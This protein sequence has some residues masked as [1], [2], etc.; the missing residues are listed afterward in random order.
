MSARKVSAGK[1]RPE[2]GEVLFL[3]VPDEPDRLPRPTDAVPPKRWFDE[4]QA[5]AACAHP[6]R[7]GGDGD[8]LVFVHGY[9]NDLKSVQSRQRYL[10]E[11]LRAWGYEGAVVA[12][13]WPSDDSTLNY[14]EDR[15]DAAAT[16]RHLVEQCVVPFTERQEQGCRINVHLLGHSTGAYVICEAFAQA[17]KN[18]DLYKKKWRVDQIGFIAGDV[19]AKTLT[20]AEQWSRPMF[21]RC[22]RVTNYFN[23]YDHVLAVS[24]AKRF[25][26]SPR[27]G[28][29]GAP[30]VGR[31]PKVAN[32]DCAPHFASLDPRRQ[33]FTGTFAHSWYIGNK[34][35][36]LDFLHTIAS[37]ID[38]HVIPTRDTLADGSF[39]LREATALEFQ[40]L[41][42]MEKNRPK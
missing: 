8:V 2:P 6:T 26:T 21:D 1:F 24:N 40:P 34:L 15:S 33:R 28:R 27:A 22:V 10:C 25:G 13:D 14:L 31:H 19:S 36:A 37:G 42:A 9:N 11:D 29:V 3:K 38:R 18:G 30:S 7:T 20:D 16:S 12:F 35:W 4:V 41:W 23:G 39:R 17:E 5:V 32:V